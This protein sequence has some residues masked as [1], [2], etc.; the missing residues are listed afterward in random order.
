MEKIKEKSLHLQNDSLKFNLII[1][2]VSLLGLFSCSNKVNETVYKY[3]S[4]EYLNKLKEFKIPM[5]EASY[6]ASKLYFKNNPNIKEYDCTLD[7]VLGDYYIFSGY[8]RIYVSKTQKYYLSGIWVNGK[9]GEVVKKETDRSVLVDLE[10]PFT[11]LNSYTA[12]IERD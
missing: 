7:I 9:T 10:I 11:E 5:K 3:N 2:L 12:I 4:K 1:I 8:P 6:M